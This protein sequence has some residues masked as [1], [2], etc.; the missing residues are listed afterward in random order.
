MDI[1]KG[2]PFHDDLEAIFGKVNSVLPPRYAAH[3]ERVARVSLPLLQGRRDYAKVAGVLGP[4]REALLY[5]NRVTLTYN[6]KGKEDT[7]VYQVDPYTLVFFKGGLYLLGFAHNRGALR[8]FAVE[9]ISSLEKGKERFEIP[10]EY[11]PEEQF[12]RSFG[13]VDEEVMPVRVR[14]SP[15]VAHMVRDRI[16][17]QSQTVAE[18]EDGSIFLSF[19]AGGR[20]EI[21]AWLLSYGSHAEIL[22]P[23]ALREEVARIVTEMANLYKSD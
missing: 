8:T 12:L 3:L 20:M 10:A 13:I 18:N 21:I 6:P 5:Q 7:T 14:F 16:W 19:A 15:A 22:E 17:H 1:L 9:R 2:T 23:P 11:K 4:L